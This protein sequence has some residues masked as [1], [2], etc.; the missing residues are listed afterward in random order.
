MSSR[1]ELTPMFLLISSETSSI[2]ATCQ[3]HKLKYTGS[4]SGLAV[5]M[6]LACERKYPELGQCGWTLLA[7]VL[8]EQ[9]H[10]KKKK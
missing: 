9:Q 2:L 6:N 3:E 10:P 5:N 7:V 1:P 8:F 4:G